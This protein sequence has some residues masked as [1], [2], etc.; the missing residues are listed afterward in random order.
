[1]D[2]F[3][4]WPYWVQGSSIAPNME[5][6]ACLATA[7]TCSSNS[8]ANLFFTKL[9]IKWAKSFISMLFFFLKEEVWQKQ[10]K[11]KKDADAHNEIK[12]LGVLQC[13]HVFHLLLLCMCSF[14]PICLPERRET[15]YIKIEPCFVK[16][17]VTEIFTQLFLRLACF[18]EL[19]KAA[20][21]Q[22]C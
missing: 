20:L 19:L 1:M 6:P 8:F 9:L 5:A 11:K 12:V 14:L 16:K 13:Y 3:Q 21:E 7:G 10:C 2:V 18:H 4:K 15:L 17:I 22:A